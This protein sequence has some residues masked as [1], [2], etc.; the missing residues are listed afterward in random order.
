L[1]S[2]SFIPL[3][4]FDSLASVT[5]SSAVW[6]G[7]GTGNV[8]SSRSLPEFD[9]L[10][11]E[12]FSFAT[13]SQYRTDFTDDY[14]GYVLGRLIVEP[15][16][17]PV[18]TIP[19]PNQPK[20]FGIWVADPFPDRTEDDLVEST[21]I[22]AKFQS[23]EGEIFIQDL[24]L[25]PVSDRAKFESSLKSTEDNNLPSGFPNW[26]YFEADIPAFTSEEY[27][28]SIHSLWIKINPIT[29]SGNQFFSQGPLV[30]DNLSV[31]TMQ[32][33]YKIVE[34]FE[35]LSTIWQTG[36]NQSI[37]SFTKH[38][39]THTGQA[40]MRLFFGA[41]G[42]SNWLVLSPATPVRKD[43][44]PVLASPVFLEM[45][46]LSVG[47]KFILNTNRLSLVFA[48]KETVNYFPTMYE[49]I[50]R[51]FLIVA[52]DPLLAELNKASRNPVNSNETWLNV[53]SAQGIPELLGQFNQASRVW[54]VE[55]ERIKFKS[56]PLT[57]GL[58][59]VI[60]LGYS[61][62]LLLSLVGFA[63]YFY[64]SA[65]R[66]S[67]IYGILRSLGLSTRQLYASLV[68]EQLILIISGLA[69]GIFLGSRLNDIVLPGLPISFGGIPPI[70]PF[71]PHEDW[72][73]VF[74][75]VVL[76]VSCFIITLAIGTYLL[77]RTKLHRVLRVG[78]E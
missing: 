68:I 28:I 64:M 74:S 26:R 55:T 59:T 22:R 50:D 66:R 4:R 77:W 47:D 45:T 19:L 63:T 70:P 40:S 11:V 78:E 13:V 52:R 6:R 65:R 44:I 62:A 21:K 14:V 37:A 67:S 20:R 1:T 76:L 32:G 17:L 31:T 8:R 10:A 43:P 51:G 46:E 29:N 49:S 2:D 57:L 71:I 15:E 54:D 61:L 5:G 39:I 24:I 27:P 53:D 3:S 73:A 16:R 42:A 48:I 9:L 56:D 41:P 60:F 12:P 23:S 58:R 35:Q 36:D 7:T 30:I 18:A 25:T 75:L 69:I 34:G 38:E 72:A 33:E